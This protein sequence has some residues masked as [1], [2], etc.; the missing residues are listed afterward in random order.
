[1]GKEVILS[2]DELSDVRDG[3]FLINRLNTDDFDHAVVFDSGN[4]LDIV[5]GSDS[6]IYHLPNNVPLQTPTLD[7][8]LQQRREDGDFNPQFSFEWECSDIK[9]ARNRLLNIYQQ[10]EEYNW[11]F[12]NCEHFA[13]EVITGQ[14]KSPQLRGAMIEAGVLAIAAASSLL[15]SENRRA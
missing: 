7:Y 15:S 2:G 11:L 10:K 1:M 8:Y 14:K 9:N 6:M 4:V 5:E 13:Y 3:L 12:N